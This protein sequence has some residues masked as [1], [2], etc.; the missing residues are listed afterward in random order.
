MAE[1]DLMEWAEKAAV[2]HLRGKLASGD[3]L[4]M[5]ANTLLS[6]LLVGS[7]GGLGYAV[8]LAEASALPP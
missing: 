3:F 5:Q 2:E 8:K 6:I 4:L 7:G 1:K